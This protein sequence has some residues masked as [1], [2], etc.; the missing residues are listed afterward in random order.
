[1]P[2]TV[3]REK[4]TK[5]FLLER[6]KVYICKTKF[7]SRKVY[8]SPRNSFPWINFVYILRRNFQIFISQCW[9]R[10]IGSS[11]EITINL[12]IGRNYV[13][14]RGMLISNKTVDPVVVI[15]ASQTMFVLF[16]EQVDRRRGVWVALVRHAANRRP[17]FTVRHIE[18]AKTT[19]DHRGQSCR[20]DSGRIYERTNT[21]HVVY[22]D[23]RHS[24]WLALTERHCLLLFLS[25]IFRSWRLLPPMYRYWTR[26]I[27]VGMTS[28]IT[29]CV[30]IH[31][32]HWLNHDNSIG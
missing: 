5:K 18:V 24:S 13:S 6:Y 2:H 30:R 21:Q 27:N 25:F 8:L 4:D 7:I 22:F 23:A 29:V 17:Y 14:I 3:H 11:S 19:D 32:N 16:S 26:C 12:L 31:H 1:M 28:S 15:R 9:N 20:F 10:H